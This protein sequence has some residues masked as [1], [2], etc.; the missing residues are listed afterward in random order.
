[1]LCVFCCND[2]FLSNIIMYVLR[3]KGLAL[4]KSSF[5]RRQ[6]QDK[7]C[8]SQYF[9]G[10]CL[11]FLL[12]VEESGKWVMLL[13]VG[14]VVRRRMRL[15]RLTQRMTRWQLDNLVRTEQAGHP[16]QAILVPPPWYCYHLFVVRTEQAVHQ[17]RAISLVFPSFYS[18]YLAILHGLPSNAPQEHCFDLGFSILRSKLT[19]RGPHLLLLQGYRCSRWRKG[20]SVHLHCRQNNPRVGDKLCRWDSFEDTKQRRCM[21]RGQDTLAWRRRYTHR[22]PVSPRFRR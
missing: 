10:P 13:S 19:Q 22:I 16:E 12:C 20:C 17:E 11:L 9:R 15:C 21:T 7:L 14:N 6:A 8:P 3:K 1:M 2:N 18:F 4:V 5:S